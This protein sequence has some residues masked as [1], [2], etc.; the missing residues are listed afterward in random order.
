ML[1]VI[2][3]GWALARLPLSLAVTLVLGLL[4]GAGI[5][6][7]PALGLVLV[8]FAIPFGSLRS[9][10]LG[11]IKLGAQDA[12][13]AL[14]AVS[15]LLRQVARRRVTW[16]WPMMGW[17]GLVLLGTLFLSFLPATSLS[18]ALKELV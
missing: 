14:V 6:L 1:L 11:D 12:L 15:W 7:R 8:A 18:A 3:A 17:A 5:L 10:S 2:G 16:R 4:V 9:L 13:L